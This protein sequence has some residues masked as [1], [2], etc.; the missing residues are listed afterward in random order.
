VT[1]DRQV[2]RHRALLPDSR[3]GYVD[4]AGNVYRVVNLGRDQRAGGVDE[5]GEIYVD[6]PDGED[7]RVGKVTGD[8]LIRAGAAALLLLL[9]DEKAD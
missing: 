4:S 5:N 9:G 1:P 7:R 6:V 8:R 3:I 2:F